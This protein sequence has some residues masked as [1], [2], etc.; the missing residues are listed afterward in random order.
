MVELLDEEILVLD[1]VEEEVQDVELEVV[2]LV[3]DE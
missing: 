3:L 1:E 2:E